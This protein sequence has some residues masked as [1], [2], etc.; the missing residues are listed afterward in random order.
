MA[1]GQ[2]PRGPL[3]WNGTGPRGPLPGPN[4]VVGSLLLCVLGPSATGDPVKETTA[5]QRYDSRHPSRATDNPHKA[6]THRSSLPSVK[7]SNDC[8][9]SPH[10]SL[11][12][13]HQ[14]QNSP[15]SSYSECLATSYFVLRKRATGERR[16]IL[17]FEGGSTRG[18][19][20]SGPLAL[21]EG[22]RRVTSPLSARPSTGGSPRTGRV[23]RGFRESPYSDLSL[24][25]PSL[26]WDNT[27]PGP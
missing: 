8:P 3:R 19:P 20:R 5:S 13:L 22:R 24:R 1:Q 11:E 10:R 27:A 14:K 4:R 16:L 2:G 9:F 18:T 26:R 15:D 7:G 6:K 12:P 21:P 17:L 23:S 25:G